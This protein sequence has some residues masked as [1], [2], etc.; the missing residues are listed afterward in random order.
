[1]GFEGSAGCFA[2]R[3]RRTVRQHLLDENARGVSPLSGS[4]PASHMRA[5]LAGCA[6]I[7]SL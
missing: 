4:V 6:G 7:S 3:Y 1:M 2:V 5:V